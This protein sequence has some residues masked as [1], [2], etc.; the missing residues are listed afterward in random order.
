MRSLNRTMF[1]YTVA[2]FKL[3]KKPH[4]NNSFERRHTRILKQST[5]NV[6]TISKQQKTISY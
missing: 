4:N 3:E 5:Q 1:R 2:V 6:Y